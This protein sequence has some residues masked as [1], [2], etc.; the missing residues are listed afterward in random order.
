MTIL[1]TIIEHKRQEVAAPEACV[2]IEA[3]RGAAETAAEPTR[4]FA[5]ALTDASRPS[6]RVI[7]EIKRRSPSKGSLC[8]D[9]DPARI[10]ALYGSNGA[11][12]VS[13]LTDERFFG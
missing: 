8:P 1:D 4:D 2:P 6:P 12:A 11:A 7:A 10:A 9:L 13:V 5:A 3:V